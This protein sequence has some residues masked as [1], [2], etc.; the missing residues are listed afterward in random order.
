MMS[1]GTGHPTS[2]CHGHE[3][4]KTMRKGSG[5][6]SSLFHGLEYVKA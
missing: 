6:L 5:Q 2:L 4:E 1:K 3:K